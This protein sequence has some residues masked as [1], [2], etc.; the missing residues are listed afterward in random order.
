MKL[1]AKHSRPTVAKQH[2]VKQTSQVGYRLGL[3]LKMFSMGQSI[4]AP[5]FMLLTI[6]P[7]S[8]LSRPTI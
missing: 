2:D 3:Y 5:N 6:G 7:K 4:C 1:V 8:C